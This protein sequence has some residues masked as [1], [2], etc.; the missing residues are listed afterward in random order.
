MTAIRVLTYL[1]RAYQA[2]PE[3]EVSGAELQHELDL[4]ADSVQ[5]Y[6]A[7]LAR[8]GLVEW[9]PLLG[10]IWLRLTDEGLR[11]GLH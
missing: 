5:R 7:E 10:N 3:A 6:V 4:D 2:N 11:A 1:S 9:D 8:Q